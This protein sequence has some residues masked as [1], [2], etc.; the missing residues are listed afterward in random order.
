MQYKYAEIGDMV[1]FW[2]AANETTGTAGDGATPLYDVRLAGAAAAAAPTTGGTPTLLS[3]ADYSPGLF[4]I[5][6]DTTGQAAGEYAVF[7]TLT[8]S[9]VNPAGFCGSYKLRPAATSIDP[10]LDTVL[11]D[12]NELQTNQGD[13]ATATGFAT[14]TNITA[15]SGI[16]LS[17][18]QAAY[19]PA[20][21]GDKMD[22]IDAPNA[23]GIS[24]IVT[25]INSLATY[26]LTAINTLLVTTGI[27]AATIP[28]PVIPTATMA[29]LAQ[30]IP[31][32][33]PTISEALMLLY[34]EK[35]NQSLTTAT[36]LGIYNDAGTKVTKAALSDD[37]TTFTKGK[38]A[39]GA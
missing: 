10:V 31:P 18:T 35:R 33:T 24:A 9:T 38:L 26:G 17:A 29:E 37:G 15:A 7:C 5:A 20:K 32:A 30:G 13:W 2:M 21:A 14:P 19:A 3:H 6:I 4:E 23:T 16:A 12:T 34:M 22:L 1:Y 8:I 11:A 27:K 36:E 39:S 28:T 25:A